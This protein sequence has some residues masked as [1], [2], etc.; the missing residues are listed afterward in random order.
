[1]NQ[2]DPE[3]SWIFVLNCEQLMRD[4][5][6]HRLSIEGNYS[7]QIA[8]LLRH[9]RRDRIFN[10]DDN[11]TSDEELLEIRT[12][13]RARPDSPMDQAR[14]RI[15]S[16]SRAIPRSNRR[17]QTR[18]V[19]GNSAITA[20]VMRRWNLQFLAKRREDAKTFLHRIEEGRDLVPVYNEDILHCL[21]FFF[22]EY[23]PPLVSE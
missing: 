15:S 23:R 17:D 7:I 18:E 6:R 19:S 22:N 10:T 3:N 8:R 12:D 2:V 13:A 5:Q 4:L 9:V 16:G 20:N 1:M 21:P 11:K 14:T